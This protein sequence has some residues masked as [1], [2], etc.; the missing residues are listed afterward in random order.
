M[1]M[2]S[3]LSQRRRLEVTDIYFTNIK[4]RFEKTEVSAFREFPARLWNDFTKSVYVLLEMVSSGLRAR[5]SD[6]RVTY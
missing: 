2:H 1:P 6:P 5:L 4:K 3:P